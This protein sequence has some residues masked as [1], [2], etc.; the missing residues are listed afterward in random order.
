MSNILQIAA[1]IVIF[2]VVYTAGFMLILMGLRRLINWYHRRYSK[3]RRIN[4]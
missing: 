1:L 4:K 3:V 2:I